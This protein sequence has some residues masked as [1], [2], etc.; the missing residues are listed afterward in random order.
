VVGGLAS[1]Q[2]AQHADALIVLADGVFFNEYPRI[3]AFTEVSRLP[4]LFPNKKIV[5]AGGLIACGPNIPAARRAEMDKILP[6]D[7]AADLPVNLTTK[8][9][10]AINLGTARALGMTIPPTLLAIAGEVVG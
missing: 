3:L 2:S 8:F 9:E 5:E 4:A 7:T 1:A 6:S 10:L